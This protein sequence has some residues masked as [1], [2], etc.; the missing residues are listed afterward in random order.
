MDD[1]GTFIDSSSPPP[2]PKVFTRVIMAPPGPPWRQRQM[3]MLEARQ[4]APIAL[5]DVAL[6]LQR[7]GMWDGRVA[8][9]VAFYVRTVDFQQ[10]IVTDLQV[11]GETV[12]LRMPHPSEERQRSATAALIGGLTAFV[13]VACAAAISGA[14]SQRDSL[15]QGVETAERQASSRLRVAQNAHRRAKEAAAL[16]AA[17]RNDHTISE[18]LADMSWVAANRAP[19]S[20]IQA[21]H[22]EGGAL[23]LEAS[24][25]NPPID[26]WDR[27][28]I[29]SAR[30]LRPGVWAWAA[31]K[32]RALKPAVAAPVA[33]QIR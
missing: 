1:S 30:P 4:S 10:S 26:A 18:V 12:R 11:D 23:A 13:V 19:G 33:S 28:L 14:A 16:A 5:A 20:R 29:R 9:F 15:T 32:P 25:S 22:W 21:F 24:G 8:R 6:R 2:T 3:A 7:M 17:S 31:A 27:P